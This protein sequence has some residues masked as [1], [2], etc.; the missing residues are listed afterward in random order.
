MNFYHSVRF[1]WCYRILLCALPFIATAGCGSNSELNLQP[2]KGRVLYKGKP[3]TGGVVLFERESEQGEPPA[4]SGTA[5]PLRA[6]GQ[7]QADGSF[8]LNAFEGASGVPQGRY[9]VGVSSVPP[10]SEANIFGG[11]VVIKKGDPD[12]LRGRYADPK[13][14]GLRCDVSDAQASEPIFDLR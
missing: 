13:T 10:R 4:G 5:G 1:A 2:V 8:S 9:R 12:V 3:L 6:T 11:T 7:I 14:S